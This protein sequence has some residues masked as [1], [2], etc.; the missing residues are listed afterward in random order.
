MFVFI[1][2]IV[3]AWISWVLVTHPDS[4]DRAKTPTGK[5]F[6]FLSFMAGFYFWFIMPAQVEQEHA[7]SYEERMKQYHET[8]SKTK[9]AESDKGRHTSWNP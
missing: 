5:V 4:K 6:G 1:L 2:F 3:A 8:D 7:E 9:R